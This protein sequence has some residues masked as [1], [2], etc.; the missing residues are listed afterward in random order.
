MMN[1]RDLG[2]LQDNPSED[3]EEPTFINCPCFAVIESSTSTD[4]PEDLIAQ[5][6]GE[7]LR[8][9]CGELAR[10]EESLDDSSVM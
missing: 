5:V 8:I 2:A 4:L 3:K 1:L 9:N 10:P 6:A 7:R